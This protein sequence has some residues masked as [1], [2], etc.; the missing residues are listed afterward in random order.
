MDCQ[1]ETRRVLGKN[2]QLIDTPG[3][4]DTDPD[5]P[6]FKREILNCMIECASG[7]HAFLLVLKVESGVHSRQSD[8]RGAHHRGMGQRN[9]VLS[10]L[11]ERCGGRCHVFDNKHWNN[12][13]DKYRNNQRQVKKLLNT[14]DQT[15]S[16]NRGRCYTNENLMRVQEKLQQ[17]RTTIRSTQKNLSEEEV[18]QKAKENT[19][20]YFWPFMSVMAGV[21]ALLGLVFFGR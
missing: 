14:I 1:S 7:V 13:P 11:V 10:M 2:V 9:E 6:D 17:E 19:Y 20:D 3:L 15:V 21:G 16:Q 8:G 5:A 18:D 12:T 4:F